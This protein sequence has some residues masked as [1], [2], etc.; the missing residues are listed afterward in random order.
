MRPIARHTIPW[1]GLGKHTLQSPAHAGTVSITTVLKCTPAQAYCCHARAASQT[2]MGLC[3]CVNVNRGVCHVGGLL[4][5]E[6]RVK[7]CPPYDTSQPYTPAISPS[8][9]LNAQQLPTPVASTMQRPASTT[10]A[11]GRPTPAGH[12]Q[13]ASP[14]AQRNISIMLWLMQ[15]RIHVQKAAQAQAGASVQMPLQALL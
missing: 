7:T 6:C 15:Q 9:M 13:V 1:A 5:Q 2:H 3:F 8:S 10:Q 4:K 12:S 11:P 14:L